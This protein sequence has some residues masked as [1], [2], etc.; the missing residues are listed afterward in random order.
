MEWSIVFTL[1]NLLADKKS[2]TAGMD[3]KLVLCF[4]LFLIVSARSDVRHSE[5]PKTCQGP[6]Q[7]A[8]GSLNQMVGS[9]LHDALPLRC[10]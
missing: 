8:G 5:S 1:E 3:V 2:K 6:A 10:H 9:V 4:G 7:A